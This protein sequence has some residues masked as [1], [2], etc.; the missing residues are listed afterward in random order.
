MARISR[1][2]APL[3]KVAEAI[4]S[5]VGMIVAKADTAKNVL[6]GEIKKHSSG[7]TIRKA[8]RKTRKV[9]AQVRKG[10]RKVRAKVS[11]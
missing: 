3:T 4:G 11:R 1:S 2:K 10:K 5:T 6:T 7:A 8:K 9:A